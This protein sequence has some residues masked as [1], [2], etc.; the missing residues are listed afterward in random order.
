MELSNLQILTQYFVASVPYGAIIA[1]IA[2]GYTMVYG[3]IQ[4]VNFAHG[5]IFMFAAYFILT[6]IAPL[7]GGAIF[8]AQASA[9][10]LTITWTTTLF[11]FLPQR[12]RGLTRWGASLVGGAVIG[13]AMF[14]V[15]VAE[16]PFLLACP[17]AVIHTATMGVT[18]DRAAYLPLRTAPRLT[19]LI[20]AIGVSFFLLNLSQGIWEARPRPFPEESVPALLRGPRVADHEMAWFEQVRET[21][22]IPLAPWLDTNVRDVVIVIICVIAMVALE[23]MIHRTRI[24]K[25]MRACSQDKI[26]SRLV[27]INVNCVVAVTFA[28]GSAM[29]AVAAPLYVLRG[30]DLLPTMGYIVGLLAFASAVLG[31]IGNIPGALLGG[32]LIGVV[33]NMAPCV[34]QLNGPEWLAAVDLSQWGYGVAYAVMI[35]VI[36]F[37]P[38]GLLG[39]SAATR[40]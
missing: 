27:G 33:T 36:I 23:L 18:M 35:G 20:T 34:S 28:I 12:L 7:E 6:M 16:V 38:T 17:L 22:R 13:G 21:G 15:F 9:V 10:I 25:A 30:P 2:V 3:I 14:P 8:W 32:F 40:A 11:V 29:A 1:L 37:R 4:L 39:K 31:G 5:E 26:T 24:G 19:A